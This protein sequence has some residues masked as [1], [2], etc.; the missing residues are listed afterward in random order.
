MRIIILLRCIIIQWH[1]VNPEDSAACHKD[2]VQ[3][4]P[5]TSVHSACHGKFRTAFTNRVEWNHFPHV[6]TRQ[7]LLPMSDD[8]RLRSH[9]SWTQESGIC[10]RP[11]L[12]IQLVRSTN[13][14]V[15]RLPRSPSAPSSIDPHAVQF[16]PVTPF[17]PLSH[18][19]NCGKWRSTPNH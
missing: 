8:L 11:H 18:F 6:L 19:L 9:S 4:R 2:W 7:I 17:L 5:V 14:L 1:S 3:P 15:P 10:C 16:T 13:N 12:F